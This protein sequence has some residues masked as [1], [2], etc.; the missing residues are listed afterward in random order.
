MAPFTARDLHRAIADGQLGLVYQPEVDLR[1]GHIA[2]V[3]ALLRWRSPEAGL[4]LPPQLIPLAERT[5]QIREITEIVLRQAVAQAAAWRTARWDRGA[6]LVW[7]NISARD[8][9][10]DRLLS[11]ITGLLEEYAVA[12]SQLGLEITETLPIV[13]SRT[14]VSTLRTLHAMGVRIALDDFG[15]GYSSLMHL[16]ALPVDVVKIDRGFIEDVTHEPQEQAI[17]AGII[18]MVHAAPRVVVAEGIEDSIQQQVLI[19]LGCD[20]G[21]GYLYSSPQPAHCVEVLLFAD[22]ELAARPDGG[23]SA[24]MALPRQRTMEATP[25][26]GRTVG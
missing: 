2:A 18:D 13:D 5:G 19:G 22:A 4:V 10:D 25:E 14:A 12:P 16:R 21:Q 23:R 11:R 7:V 20:L 17:V 3:E 1:T 6:L 24:L 9:T 26:L 15:T 8:L